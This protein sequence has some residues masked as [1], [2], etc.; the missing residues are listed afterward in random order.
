MKDCKAGGKFPYKADDLARYMLDYIT[1]QPQ[2]P[3]LDE[4]TAD[5]EGE[6][7]PQLDVIIN[8]LESKM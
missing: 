1:S 8:E 6:D 5:S 3:D 2:I 7:S 4:Q